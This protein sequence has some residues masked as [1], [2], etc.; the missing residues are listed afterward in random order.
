M[1]YIKSL[2]KR[3][4]YPTIILA[5]FMGMMYFAIVTVA[6]INLQEIPPEDV[7]FPDLRSHTGA[8]HL[9]FTSAKLYDYAIIGGEVTRNYNTTQVYDEPH[10]ASIGQMFITIDLPDVNLVYRKKS[11]E[12]EED[13]EYTS[14][15]YYVYR[16]V[17][18]DEEVDHPSMVIISHDEENNV[19]IN[20]IETPY[21]IE[22]MV[23]NYEVHDTYFKKI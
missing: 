4:E 17:D 5:L 8:V 23:D 14:Y 10:R 20:I 9:Y 6:Q 21:V 3:L 11:L 19:I 15:I 1:K 7:Q 13:G 16:K 18:E 2:F 12:V 22:M